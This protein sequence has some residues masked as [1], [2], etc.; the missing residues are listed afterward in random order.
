MQCHCAKIQ[1]RPH[2]YTHSG[3][4]RLSRGD[5]AFQASSEHSELG[6]SSENDINLDLTILTLS[7]NQDAV[8]I[9]TQTPRAYEK[10]ISVEHGSSK[11]DSW[12]HVMFLSRRYC[13]SLSQQYSVGTEAR[14]S[15]LKQACHAGWL[16]AR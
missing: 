1:R 7:S 9:Y 11:S 15:T 16:L 13:K 5:L 3:V 4:T 14:V 12:S 2:P 6:Y 10:T 8:S